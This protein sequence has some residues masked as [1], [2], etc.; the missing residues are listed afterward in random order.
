LKRKKAIP[1]ESK[2]PKR[3]QPGFKIDEG[4]WYRLKRL[5]LDKRRTSTELM[6]E[7]VKE[8]LERHGKD[9]VV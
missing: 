6:E 2:K 4:L 1:E 9:N 5:A 8:Y 7:A 3:I